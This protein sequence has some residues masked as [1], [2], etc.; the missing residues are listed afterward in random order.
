MLFISLNRLQQPGEATIGVNSSSTTSASTSK[1]GSSIFNNNEKL[2]D[3][4]WS[5]KY[6]DVDVMKP[7]YC[8]ETFVLMIKAITGI[9][10]RF[11]FVEL[12]DLNGLILFVFVFIQTDIQISRILVKS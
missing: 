5:C 4:I 6:S 7:S 12:S 9:F 1:T 2:I 11:Y 3:E 10:W 8:A